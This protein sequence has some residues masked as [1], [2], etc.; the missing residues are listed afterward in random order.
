MLAQKDMSVPTVILLGYSGGGKTYLFN[1]LTGKSEPVGFAAETLTPL[2]SYA[3]CCYN[4]KYHLYDTPGIAEGSS[5]G[6]LQI[7]RSL[8]ILSW[9]LLII[10]CKITNRYK[11]DSVPQ[12]KKF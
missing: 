4:Q 2:L 12:I 3:D 9:N 11:I 5:N 7:Q 6:V 8:R 1:N 10:V